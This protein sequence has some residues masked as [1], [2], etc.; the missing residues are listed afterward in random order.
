MDDSI[1]EKSDMFNRDELIKLGIYELRELGRDIGVSSPTTLKKEALVDAIL[2]IIYGEKPKRAIGKGRGR[3]A[4][5][6]EKPSKLFVDL[7]QKIE[8]PQVY[9]SILFGEEEEDEVYGSFMSNKVASPQSAYVNDAAQNAGTRVQK[10]VVC[11]DG[12]EFFARKL[13]FVA[14]D[15]DYKL[16]ASIVNKYQL[17]DNDVIEFLV[18][19]NAKKVLQV[20]KINEEMAGLKL[21]NKVKEVYEIGVLGKVLKTNKSNL[22]AI[23]K[24]E[25]DKFINSASNRFKTEGYSVIKVGY[26]VRSDKSLG[27]DS[28]S[29]TLVNDEYESIAIT[30]TAVERAKMYAK[31]GKD[32]VIIIEDIDWLNSVIATYPKS[33][34]GNFISK[35]ARLSNYEDLNITTLC[36]TTKE[37]NPEIEK[38]FDVVI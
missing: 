15:N 33:L 5:T 3:P 25:V 13:R 27:E 23:S 30:E 17:K 7:I 19:S 29:L 18:D 24:Q 14:S 20:V 34:Y 28:F 11:E 12:N 26:T 9:S 37:S 21:N 38:N 32:V 2:S 16:D 31:S 6:G 1:F 10:G 8:E 22:V 36:L 4:R 35:L